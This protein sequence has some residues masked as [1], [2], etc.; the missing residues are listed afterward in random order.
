MDQPPESVTIGHWALIHDPYR[1]QDAVSPKLGSHDTEPWLP[2]HRT[3][4]GCRKPNPGCCTTELWIPCTTEPWMSLHQA[5]DDLLLNLGCRTT[6]S[7]MTYYSTLDA[8]PSNH[9]SWTTEPWVPY[10][11]TLHAVL[12]N[13]GCRTTKH[14]MPYYRTLDAVTPNHRFSITK[15]WITYNETCVMYETRSRI[16]NHSPI[17]QLWIPHSYNHYKQMI[18]PYKTILSDHVY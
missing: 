11:Q 6:E 18:S 2:C 9:V 1:T 10:Y 16:H 15:S 3:L 8:V 4:N 5:M 12:Q 7:W 14:W 17:K 13:I